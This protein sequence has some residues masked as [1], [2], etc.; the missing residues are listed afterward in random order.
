VG[1]LPEI[2]VPFYCLNYFK[3]SKVDGKV[4]IDY[5]KIDKEQP[6]ELNL[7]QR[8]LVFKKHTKAQEPIPERTFLEA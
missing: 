1:F 4:A 7:L 6:Q 3:I 8:L 5:H 2:Y